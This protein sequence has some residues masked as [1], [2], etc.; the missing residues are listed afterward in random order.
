MDEYEK[1][2]TY[3]KLYL[4]YLPKIFGIGL[5]KTGTSSLGD[6]FELLGYKLYCRPTSKNIEIAKRNPEYFDKIINE[7]QVFEDWPWALP[8]L[9]KY[10]YNKYP[11]SKFILTMRENEEKWFDSLYRHSQRTGPTEQR[12]Q[13]YGYHD[14]EPKN[15]DNKQQHIKIYMKHYE[16]VINFFNNSNG[17]SRL[18]ILYVNDENKEKKIHEFINRPFNKYNFIKYPHSNRDW[19]NKGG[20]NKL[21]VKLIDH[22]Y[23]FIHVPKNAGTSFIK[24]LCGNKQIG[25]IRM[26]SINDINIVKKTITIT[27]NPY[28]RLYSIYSY[29]KL[30]KEKSYW[31]KNEALYNYVKN[32]SFKQFVN[33]LFNK[34]IK[35]TDQIHLSPQSDYIKWKDGKIHNILIKLE[36]INNEL[37]KLLKV[38]IKIPKINMSKDVNNWEKQYNDDMKEKVYLL[39]KKD[40]DLLNYK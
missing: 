33:D 3:K 16:N 28:D 19:N 31:K 29:T 4:K 8:S 35:F 32:N 17:N 40:F 5:N 39:Y 25:H 12:K 6:Y 11:T 9:Y 14:P 24:Y 2:E 18:L 7:H 13:I 10:I 15:N 27:R 36:N 23:Y 1:Y 26:K 37:S 30:G 38:D 34:K 22:D 21:P 20:S